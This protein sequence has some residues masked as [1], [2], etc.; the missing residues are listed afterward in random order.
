MKQC[1]AGDFLRDLVD[2]VASSERDGKKF[3]A[4]AAILGPLLCST[5]REL[6][7]L[8][9]RY[10]ALKN[11]FWQVRKSD[12]AKWRV[13]SAEIPQLAILDGQADG[14]DRPEEALDEAILRCALRANTG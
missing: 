7:L 4:D 2:D 10:E 6:T 5:S 13:C 14:F 8:T 1:H 12:D 11:K 3:E 9:L